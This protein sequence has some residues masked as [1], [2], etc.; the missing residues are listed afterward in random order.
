MVDYALKKIQ[1]LLGIHYSQGDGL[2]DYVMAHIRFDI[3]FF[4]MVNTLYAWK[5]QELDANRLSLSPISPK[6][7]NH[8]AK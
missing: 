7:L 3:Q 4:R 1:K 6:G 8:S 5:H 2:L